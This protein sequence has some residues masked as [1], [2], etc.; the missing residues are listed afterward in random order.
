VRLVGDQ[1]VKPGSGGSP[2]PSRSTRLG[3]AALLV[4]AVQF[5]VAMAVTQIGWTTP[6]SLTT[7]YISDLGAA[8]CGYWTGVD[9][10][11]ICSPWHAVFDSSIVILGL[12]SII[13]AYLI[14]DAL[15]SGW[16]PALG[17]VLFA[18]SGAGAIGV[19]LSPE[20]VNLQVHTASA[21]LS[22]AAGNTAL[23]VLGAAMW[24]AAPWGPGFGAVGLI[25]GAVG[26][27]ALTVFAT[28]HWGPVGPGGWE[29]LIVAP[30]LMWAAVVGV[31]L[32]ASR[33]GASALSLT[34]AT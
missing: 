24:R 15:R 18:L 7:N 11:Y 4:G 26:W 20:D 30:V 31:R 14:R 13:A 9:P 6:Y 21:L 23:L 25:L 10:R 16:F 5:V 1:K 34:P 8:H 29:R 32:L 33:G 27:V 2:N 12:L 17:L 19:G 3:G 28:G 22:F